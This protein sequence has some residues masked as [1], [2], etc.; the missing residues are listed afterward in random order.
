MQEEAD[1]DVLLA[2]ANLLAEHLR[3]QHQVIVVHPDQISI[4]HF[5]GNGLG[6]EA[7]RFFIR[8]PGRLVERNFAWVVVEERPEDGI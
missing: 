3:Q 7:V 4:L 6:E 2:V 5:L 8:L 1:L